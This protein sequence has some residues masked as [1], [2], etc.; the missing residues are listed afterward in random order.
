VLE[1][2]AGT[3]PDGEIDGDLHV[4]IA[5]GVLTAWRTRQGWQPKGPALNRLAVDVAT[6]V[7][8]RGL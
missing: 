3:P 7:R 1:V 8:R 4:A 5:D 2:A 6:I